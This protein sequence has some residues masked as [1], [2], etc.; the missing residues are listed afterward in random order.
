M[1]NPKWLFSLLLL[2]ACA[3]TPDPGEL[4]AGTVPFFGK[5]RAYRHQ[6][7]NGLKLVMIRDTSS[8]TFSIQTWFNVG[9]R[10][11]KKGYTGLAH[12]FEHMMFKQTK[13][14]KE[15]EFDKQLEE[16][17]AE[18]E[19]A[20]TSHDYTAYV[21]ELPSDRLELVLK[22]ESDRMVNLIVDDH[23]FK[24]EREVVQNERRF[25]N[26]NSPDGTMWQ[27]LFNTA[28][29]THPYH[30]PVI[31]YEEDLKRMSAE[32]A[33]KFYENYYAPNRATIVIVGD[34]DPFYTF[35]LV[36]QYYGKIRSRELAKELV[37]SIPAEPEQKSARQK[38]MKLNIQVEKLMMAYHVPGVA[39]DDTSVLAVIQALLTE[40]KNPR[41]EKSLV[42]SG[43]ASH[44]GSGSYENVDPS[45]FVFTANLQAKKKADQAVDIILKELE[46][47]KTQ[48]VPTEELKKAKNIAQFQFIESFN[49]NSQKAHFIGHY[50]TV[51][52]HFKEG[53]KSADSVM[54]VNS[55]DIMRVAKKYF[56]PTNRTSITGVPK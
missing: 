27:E 16:A 18:G 11:E 20:F 33:R 35:K 42:D 21:Q 43:I 32:D 6:L 28:Y 49:S 39:S 53:I 13:N 37:K 15:G 38:T 24:T 5:Y 30:W 31:G 14:L 44:V 47:L 51:L 48:K 52:G 45:L 56:S 9:S 50:E 2:S 40:G 41:L 54:N 29:T 17:G 23:A 36:K 26:E 10:N 19:N 7:E 12:L 22:L 3:S 4:E 25:R 34:I 46:R 1:K 8:P 55:V